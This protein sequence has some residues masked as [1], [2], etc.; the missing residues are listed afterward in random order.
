MMHN[1]SYASISIEIT[2]TYS[3]RRTSHVN[4][5]HQPTRDTIVINSNMIIFLSMLYI[6]VTN[7]IVSII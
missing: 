3:L 1:E 5:N 7:Y 2:Y 4:V 6:I